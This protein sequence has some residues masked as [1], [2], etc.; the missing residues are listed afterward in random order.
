MIV[1]CPE[2]GKENITDKPIQPNKRYRCGK[3]GAVI[4]FPQTA[5]TLTEIPKE[6]TVPKKQ[7][8]LV[9]VPK[10]KTRPSKREEA[11]KEQVPKTRK[12]F[13]IVLGVV[14]V[15]AII[16]YMYLSGYIG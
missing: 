4:T 9:E 1:K 13:L 2:C 6:E 12:G 14:A 5:D 7:D 16:V 3:C 11:K 15:I 10:E 8:T